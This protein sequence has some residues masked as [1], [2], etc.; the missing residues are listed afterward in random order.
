MQKSEVDNSHPL[1]RVDQQPHGE[2]NNKQHHKSHLAEEQPRAWPRRARVRPNR[3]RRKARQRGVQDDPRAGQELEAQE[4]ALLFLLALR[5]LVDGALR[6]LSVLRGGEAR[7]AGAE[8]GS[9]DGGGQA[10]VDLGSVFGAEFKVQRTL[11]SNDLRKNQQQYTRGRIIP[12][13]A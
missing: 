11:N 12:T 1:L 13:H 9:A 8:E 3:V 2:L 10:L 6:L 4:D 5:R 7:P